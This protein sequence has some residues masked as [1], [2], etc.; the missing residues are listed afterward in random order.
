MIDLFLMI[1][2]LIWI[3]IASFD[4]IRKREVPNWLNFSLIIFAVAYRVIYSVVNSDYYFLMYGLIGLGLFV[5][6]AYLFYYARVFAGGD[7]KL[8]MGLGAVL[9]FTTGFYSNLKILGMF[10]LL[11]MLAG[12]VYGLFYSIA[13]SIGNFRSFSR[14]MKNQ[15]KKRRSFFIISGILAI[16][17]LALVFYIP[18]FYLFPIFILLIPLMF[19]Y[20]KSVEETCLIKEISVKELTVGD[21]LYKPINIHGKLIKPNWEGV[22]EKEIKLLKNIKKLKIKQGIPFVPAFLIAFILLILGYRYLNY[23][24]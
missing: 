6:V 14:E 12:G 23:L 15:F 1:L 20:A 19:I 16:L 4:D 8:L 7:A 24:I 18:N 13:L 10:I 9:P 21:W 3:A 17:S 2:A 11:L 5:G 22:S